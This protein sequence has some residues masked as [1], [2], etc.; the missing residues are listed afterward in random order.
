VATHVSE[1]AAAL[2]SL[3]WLVGVYADNTP[4]DHGATGMGWG[5]RYSPSPLNPGALASPDAIACARRVVAARAS[6]QAAGQSLRSVLSATIGLRRAAD[7]LKPD[8]VHYHHAEL[9]PLLGRLAGLNLPSVVT[10]HSLSSFRVPEARALQALARDN[11]GRAGAVLCVSADAAAE[12]AREVPGL[13][14]EVVPNGI[15]LETFIR[16]PQARPWSG[17][18]PLVLYVGRVERDKGV[19]ELARAMAAVRAGHPEATLAL[20]G[21]A[22]DVDVAELVHEA[23]LPA[24]AVIAPGPV[25]P[26]EVPAWLHAA[27]VLVLPSRVREGQPRVI[28][29]AMAARVP[30]VASDVGGVRGLLADGRLGT[31]VPPGD[32]SAL[33]TGIRS[34]V[35]EPDATDAAVE[36]A[37]DAVLAFDTTAVS[38]RV[39]EVYER[40]MAESR[41]S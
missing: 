40:V 30:V 13:A 25:A 14:P 32:V 28:M 4:P 6:L 38:R 27:D 5:D 33:E 7:A 31:L 11:L 12:L 15:D 41:P 8:I 34:T 36:A 39:A 35:E 9:R 16:T 3:G 24:D 29:E 1:L 26:D 37:F 10:A 21:P 18:G 17:T 22:I 2:S 19:P 20:V 23:G